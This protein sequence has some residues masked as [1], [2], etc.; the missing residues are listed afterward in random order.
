VTGQEVADPRLERFIV[1]AQ[2]HPDRA[3]AELAK[4]GKTVAWLISHLPESARLDDTAQTLSQ[5][6]AEAAAIPSTEAAAKEAAESSIAA[7]REQLGRE[8]RQV[9]A[10]CLVLGQ[11]GDPAALPALCELLSCSQA[12]VAQEARQAILVI[13]VPGRLTLLCDAFRVRP[14]R[15]TAT[16]LGSLHEALGA[17][18]CIAALESLYSPSDPT[19][20]RSAVIAGMALVDEPAGRDVLLR[21][22]QNG[23]HLAFTALTPA[24]A[25]PAGEPELRVLLQALTDGQP[26]KQ[27]TAAAVLGQAGEWARPQV[28]PLLINALE[29]GDPRLARHAGASLKD[30]TGQR[31]GKDAVAWHEWWR[32]QEAE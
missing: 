11:I 5:L 31:R 8:V 32:E 3:A 2:E 26:L 21:L 1:V 18:S 4:T 6:E 19:E 29:S 25:T 22:A 14:N 30:V 20:R 27:A 9:S 28:V 16:L 7:R 17:Q 15:V 13:D 23:E 12:P 24:L 10:L